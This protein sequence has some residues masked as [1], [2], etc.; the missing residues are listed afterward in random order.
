MGWRLNRNHSDGNIEFN[1]ENGNINSKMGSN[2]GANGVPRGWG[3]GGPLLM[4]IGDATK[5]NFRSF[6]RHVPVIP[7]FC[8][9]NFLTFTILV[10]HP[11]PTFSPF[12]FYFKF[13]E[14]TILQ[15]KSNPIKTFIIAIIPLLNCLQYNKIIFF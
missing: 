12:L 11:L 2:G 14:S 7:E 10:S 1:F 15:T 4:M 8:F 6:L 9:V 5:S 3:G 13:L